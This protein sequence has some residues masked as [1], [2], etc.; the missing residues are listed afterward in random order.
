MDAFIASAFFTLGSR[1]DDLMDWAYLIDMAVVSVYEVVGVPSLKGLSAD[2]SKTVFDVA[3]KYQGRWNQEI[4][5]LEKKAR[6]DM[7]NKGKKMLQATENDRAKATDIIKPYW[8]EWAKSVGPN[9]VEALQKVRET[10]N[11]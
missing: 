9:A 1:W 11:K 4:V 3:V 10:L 2:R 8:A 5:E 6:V 7:A